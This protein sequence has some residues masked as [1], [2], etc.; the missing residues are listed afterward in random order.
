[1]KKLWRFVLNRGK[2]QTL[3]QDSTNP[4][5]AARN[6]W[7]LR[8]GDVIQA[9]YNWQIAAGLSLLCNLFLI[10][11]FIYLSSQSR[12]IPYAVKVDSLGHFTYGG[13]LT[14][15]KQ[16]TPLEINAFLRR[17]ILQA[18]AILIDPFAQKNAVEFVYAVSSPMTRRI[19]DHFYQVNNPFEKAKEEIIEVNVTSVLQKSSHT[20][21]V[22]WVDVHR[23]LQGDVTQQ[24]SWEALITISQHAIKEARLLNINPLGIYVDHISWT[25]ES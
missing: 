18:R 17:Y 5:V 14:E 7:N 25:E 13:P 15:F 24:K 19:L 20:W 4:Y 21:Q 12:Y 8:Y 2:K 6:E 1:M 10:L 11:G 22:A 9:K 3:V 23:N 16:V